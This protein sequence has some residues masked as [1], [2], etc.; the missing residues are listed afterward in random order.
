M[1]RSSQ[2]FDATLSPCNLTHWLI[3]TQAHADELLERRLVLVLAQALE[4]IVTGRLHRLTVLRAFRYLFY[5]V[6]KLPVW[7]STS[8]LGC[9]AWTFVS[10]HAIELTRPRGQ[11]R[12]DG[13]ESPRDRADAATEARCVDGVGRPNFI[14]TQAATR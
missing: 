7:K 8:E 9:I 11:R 6:K 3:S 10:L 1:A 13:V 4:P 14:S 5:F 2:A 12:V